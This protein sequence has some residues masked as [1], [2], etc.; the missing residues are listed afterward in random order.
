MQHFVLKILSMLHWVFHQFLGVF[1][2]C[3]NRYRSELPQRVQVMYRKG[4][5]KYDCI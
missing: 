3:S 5:D 4:S 2:G 1:S